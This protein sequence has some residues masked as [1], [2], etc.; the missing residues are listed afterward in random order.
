M[1]PGRIELAEPIFFQKDRSRVRHQFFTEL[2]QLARVLQ[3]RTDLTLIWIEG[4]ADSTGPE[5]W[6]LELSRSRS[7]AVAKILIAEG[8]APERLRPVGYG[9]AR[10][11]VT[12]P[13][14]ESNERNRRVHF[15]TESS[16]PQALP[17]AGTELAPTTGDQP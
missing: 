8:I 10:P 15:F 2:Q 11:L 3:K 9:E 6:N 16:D 1:H 17:P 13:H 4:H 7:A 12:T 14:G 5:R